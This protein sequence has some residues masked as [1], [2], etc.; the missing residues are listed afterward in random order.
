MVMIVLLNEACVRDA[1]RKYSA[2]FLRTRAAAL[3]AGDLAIMIF[4]SLI[5]SEPQHPFARTLASTGVCAGT[6]TA[7]AGHDDDG[8]RW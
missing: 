6:L 5:S 8:N 3:F 1:V 4:Q 2:T 7:W